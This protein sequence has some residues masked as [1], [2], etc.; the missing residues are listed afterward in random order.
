MIAAVNVSSIAL[1][2]ERWRDCRQSEI[3]IRFLLG[4]SVQLARETDM[5]LNPVSD[6]S[7][8]RRVLFYT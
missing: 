2:T 5:G 3:I 4:V 8:L 7:D 6:P 1:K